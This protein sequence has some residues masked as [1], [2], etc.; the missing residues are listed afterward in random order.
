M[1]DASVP[2]SGPPP[3]R[4]SVAAILL[5]AILGFL[6][7]DAL[8]P[9]ERQAG[10]KVAVFAVDLW[11][12]TGSRAL[13][14]AGLRVCRYDPSCSSYGREALSRYGLARGSWLTVSRIARCRPGGGQG[15]DPVP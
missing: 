13:A 6:A 2:P 10:V 9:P 4:R 5:A 8:R 11:R 15:L 1:P 14:G 7:G 12:A 3:A